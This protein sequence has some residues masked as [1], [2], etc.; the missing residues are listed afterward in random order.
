MM[1][2]DHSQHEDPDHSIINNNVRAGE[3]HAGEEKEAAPVV[4]SKWVHVL[5]WVIIAWLG[6]SVVALW[7]QE[8]RLA[9]QA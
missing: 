5:T 6:C 3:R 2:L 7:R 8:E 1:S 9:K 4:A